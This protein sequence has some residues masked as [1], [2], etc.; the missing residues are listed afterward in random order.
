MKLRRYIFC[1]MPGKPLRPFTL[2]KPFMFWFFIA[3]LGYFFLAITFILD[4]RILTKSVDKPIVY[5]FYSTIVMLGV[6][7]A[8]PFGVVPLAGNDWWIAIISG[9]AF[10]LAL[11]TLYLAVKK[12]EASHMN[13]F[14]GAIVTVAVVWLSSLWLG[15][16][17]TAI[18]MIAVAILVLATLLLSF[19]K[20]A[21]HSG[22]HSGF[23]WATV[24][25]LLFALSHVSAKYLYTAYPFLTVLVWTRAAIGL[26]GLALLFLPSVRHHLTVRHRSRRLVTETKRHALAIVLGNK[27]L[28]VVAVVLIQYAMAIGSVS[29]V[30]AMSGIQ[31]GM[32]F[33]LIYLCTKFAPK[34]FHEYFTRKELF[35]QS[36]AIVLLVLGSAMLVL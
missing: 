12:G 1:E 4:K 11:G 29:L 23:F 28:G 14:N 7:F 2:F 31:F 5:T 17:L 20:T 10:G 36:T 8:W 13:P 35:A 25:G 30:T 26:V 18:Q 32:M 24:S 22:F 34:V 9:V 6:L 27:L 33:F 16:Q 21:H 19:E 15:E 3:L